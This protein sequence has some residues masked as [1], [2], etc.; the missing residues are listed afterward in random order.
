MEFMSQGQGPPQVSGTSL[1]TTLSN[2]SPNYIS[3]QQISKGR[4]LNGYVL[5]AVAK[6]QGSVT[7]L[8][9]ELLYSNN[10]KAVLR[11]SISN[12]TQEQL[13]EL[14]AER[15][16]NDQNS[17]TAKA[18][19]AETQA[20]AENARLISQAQP[21]ASVPIAEVPERSAVPPET[22]NRPE[23]LLKQAPD[24][25]AVPTSA[26][27]AAGQSRDED[28]ALQSPRFSRRE[29][30]MERFSALSGERSLDSLAQLLRQVE[31]EISQ[32][33]PLL[34]SDGSAALRLTV[35]AS[36]GGEQASQFFI[37][38]GNC[39][40]LTTGNNGTWILEIV[41][42]RGTMSASVIVLAGR[43]AIEYPLAVAPPLEIFDAAT[44]K[45][46]VAEFVKAANEI[47]CLTAL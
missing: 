15:A 39:T 7:S 3:L 2:V 8:N 32:A 1:V 41:P 30:L 26:A 24:R 9:G 29:S 37:F 43:D 31:P 44:T 34:L 27:T 35:R 11:G 10:T 22:D 20:A 16:K 42:K 40:S 6:F 17:A 47:V 12:P 38:D 46:G 4:S 36:A 23:R 18:D 13:A 21:D 25:S 5:L 33:P 28:S 19:K 14:A 45:P